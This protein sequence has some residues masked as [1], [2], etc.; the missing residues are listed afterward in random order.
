MRTESRPNSESK[1]KQTYKGFI[2]LIPVLFRL[3]IN[4]SFW[5]SFPSVTFFPH[6]TSLHCG[7]NCHRMF[8]GQ[9]HLR[10][11]RDY[12]IDEQ[13]KDSLG[14]TVRSSMPSS[15]SSNWRSLERPMLPPTLAPS[16]CTKPLL[17]NVTCSTA[18]WCDPH[19]C[20]LFLI[21][22]HNHIAAAIP[23][24]TGQPTQKWR[25]RCSATASYRGNT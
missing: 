22:V 4:L 24:H 13:R 8:G 9:R 21:S 10:G 14:N 1:T 19:S 2:Q 5:R 6:N 11:Q 17:E 16:S 20:P 7:V 12:Q 18:L 23:K 3:F 25:D 15:R